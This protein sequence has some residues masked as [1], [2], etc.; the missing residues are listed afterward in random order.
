[1]VE[2]I[3]N[4]PRNAVIQALAPGSVLWVRDRRVATT[5]SRRTV[6]RATP[7]SLISTDEH[8]ARYYLFWEKITTVANDPN[9][10]IECVTELPKE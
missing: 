9:V 8:G 1:M 6:V 5:W 10:P 3:A 2:I 4:I 7:R